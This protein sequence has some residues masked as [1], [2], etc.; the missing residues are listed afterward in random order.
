MFVYKHI[1]APVDFSESSRA[2]GQCAGELA[3]RYDA[4]LALLHVIDLWSSL[5]T[6]RDSIPHLLEHDWQAEERLLVDRAREKLSQL[7]TELGL[8]EARQ[9]IRIGSAKKE[10]IDVADDRLP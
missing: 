7:T 8:E 9:L 10:I 4:Q 5:S 3:R 2:V 1:L 6:E